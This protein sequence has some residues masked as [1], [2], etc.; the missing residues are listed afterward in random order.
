MFRLLFAAAP[1]EDFSREFPPATDSE[2]ADRM[3]IE[4]GENEGMAFHAG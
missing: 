4:R 2:K 3:A 1:L